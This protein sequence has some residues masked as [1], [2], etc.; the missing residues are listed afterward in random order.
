MAPGEEG[1]SVE[2]LHEDRYV[3][4]IR[5]DP[6]HDER[7]DGAERPLLTCSSYAEAR[8]IRR[9]YLAANRDCVIRY[10]GPAGGGD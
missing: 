10:V 7:P 9:Q 2:P 6:G 1:A 8:R 4:Y 3:V 5:V